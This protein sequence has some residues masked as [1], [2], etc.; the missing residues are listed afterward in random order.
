MVDYTYLKKQVGSEYVLNSL[1][2][3]LMNGGDVK[4]NF[5]NNNLLF[6]VRQT[7]SND[8]KKFFSLQNDLYVPGKKPYHLYEDRFFTHSFEI[9]KWFSDTIVH[10]FVS[11]EEGSEKI[12]KI[13]QKEDNQVFVSLSPD[14]YNKLLQK[15]Q[16]YE[17][18]AHL[19]GVQMKNELK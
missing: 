4:Q 7:Q 3:S 5:E 2:D 15:V 19:F 1:T 17:F 16:T 18:N 11:F 6:F 13:L 8:P 10:T 14:T 9:N 12:K